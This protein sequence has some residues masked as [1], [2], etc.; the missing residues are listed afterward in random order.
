MEERSRGRWVRFESVRERAAELVLMQ[1]GK[2]KWLRL[3]NV[4]SMMPLHPHEEHR[5]RTCC[6]GQTSVLDLRVVI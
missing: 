5:H 1:L 4:P 6:P 3:R 2:E